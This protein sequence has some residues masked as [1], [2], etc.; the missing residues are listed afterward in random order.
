MSR[1]ELFRFKQFWVDQAGCAMKINTDGVLLGALAASPQ[2]QRVMDVGAGTGVIAL[3]LAQRYR[4]ARVE[5]VEMDRQAADRA[6][7]NFEQSPFASRL[8]LRHADFRELPWPEHDGQRYDLMVS[9]PPF[10][11]DALHSPKAQTNLAKHADEDFF[12]SLVEFCM[13][14]LTAKGLCWFIFPVSLLDMVNAS[15]MIHCL[16]PQ[17]TIYI[18]SFPHSAPHRVVVAYCY[19]PESP[20]ERELVIYDA[21][22]VYSEPYKELLKDFLTIF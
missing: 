9:N 10:Y 4:Q 14:N 8:Y 20:V 1:S 22:K 5:A 3:M 11:V 18:K 15:A 21:V 16:Y 12:N 2:P 13:F 7:Q 19:M 17:Q 6:R